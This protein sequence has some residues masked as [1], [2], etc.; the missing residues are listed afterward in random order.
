MTNVEYKLRRK[1]TG[2]IWWGS[3][4]FSPIKDKSGRIVG[5]IVACRDIT[6]RKRAEEAL[7]E[8]EQRYRTLFDTMVESY[9]LSEIVLDKN[10]KAVDYRFIDVNPSFEKFTGLS[11]DTISCEAMFLSF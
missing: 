1:D 9:A 2:E 11:R 10:G 4:D 8:S 3:Y 7:R 5:A 6:E